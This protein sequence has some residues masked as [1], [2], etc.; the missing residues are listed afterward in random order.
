MEGQ[1]NKSRIYERLCRELAAVFLPHGFERRDREFFRA[2]DEVTQTVVVPLVTYGTE[3]HWSLTFGIRVESV[4]AIYELFAPVLPEYRSRTK[5]C[6]FNL[7]DIA[8]GVSGWIV[9]PDTS[10]IRQS[11]AQVAPILA[12]DIFP[13]LDAHQDLPSIDNLMNG[14]SKGLFSHAAEP[15]HSMEAIIVAHLARNPQLIELIAEYRKTLDRVGDK[16]LAM[17]DRLVHSLTQPEPSSGG[18]MVSHPS[19]GTV[20]GPEDSDDR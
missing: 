9:V 20:G 14:A 2:K 8:S 7:D 10:L 16:L 3:F 4:Q 13:L 15:Y 19:E 5:T 6:S 17:Y 12:Q 1:M 18:T 11:V